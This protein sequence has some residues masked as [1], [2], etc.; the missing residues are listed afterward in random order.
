MELSPSTPG[1]ARDALDGLAHDLRGMIGIAI[2]GTR[3]LAQDH[4]EDPLAA[5]TAAACKRVALVV[6]RLIGAARVERPELDAAATPL[7]VVVAAAAA[8]ARREGMASRVEIGGEDTDITCQLVAPLVERMLADLMHLTAGSEGLGL[9]ISSAG[10]TARVAGA[11]H[12]EAIS[13]S[14]ASEGAA[15]LAS[16]LA[17]AIAARHH[18]TLEL[19]VQAGSFS[20]TLPAAG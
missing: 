7:T 11:R 3:L 10:S 20:V 8:R 13:D 19:D 1:R 2:A 14:A 5:D 9:Q 4:P 16:Q 15:A 18:G 12:G 17:L 6:E